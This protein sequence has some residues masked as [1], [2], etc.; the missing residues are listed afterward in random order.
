M[1]VWKLEII[2]DS[3]PAHIRRFS[4]PC[5]EVEMELLPAHPPQ[6]IYYI[7]R[8]PAPSQNPRVS[9]T[10]RVGCGGVHIATAPPPSPGTDSALFECSSWG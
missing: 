9:A 4:G 1:F 8:V 6:D 5:E 3:S 7:Y 10:R 2:P